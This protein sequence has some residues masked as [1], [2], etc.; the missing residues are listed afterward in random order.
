[1]IPVQS[2]HVVT[3]AAPHVYQNIGYKAACCKA[4]GTGKGLCLGL[5]L[6][7]GLWGP[8]ALVGIGVVSGYYYWKKASEMLD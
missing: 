6:G 4:A 7:L 2:P 5:G 1:M 3:V 8:V